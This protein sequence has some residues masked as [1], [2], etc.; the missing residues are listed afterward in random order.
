VKDCRRP[1]KLDTG[2]AS[3][4]K[5]TGY[6]KT[7]QK[8]QQLTVEDDSCDEISSEESSDDSL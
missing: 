1:T 4:P 7:E 2:T 8:R 3:Y 5:D 6:Q